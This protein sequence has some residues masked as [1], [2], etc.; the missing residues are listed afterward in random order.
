MQQYCFQRVL[1]SSALSCPCKVFLASF[2]IMPLQLLQ[3]SVQEPCGE[4]LVAILLLWLNADALCLR[5]LPEHF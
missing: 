1:S 2:S 3:N 5:W 4:E